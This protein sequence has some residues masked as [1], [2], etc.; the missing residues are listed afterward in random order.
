MQVAVLVL[1]Q[2]MD[3]SLSITLD[4]ISAANQLAGYQGRAAPFSVVTAGLGRRVQAGSGLHIGGLT[5]LRALGV[6]ALVVVP[7]AR[8]ALPAQLDAWLASPPLRRAI[9]WLRQQAQ[10]GAAVAASCAGTFVLAEAGL[11]QGRTATTTWWL[12]PHFRQRYPGVEL[13]MQQMVVGDAQVR[14][15]GAAFSQADLMLELVA[16]HAGPAL[17]QDCARYLMLDRRS[18]QM[19]YAIPGHLAR[20][21]PVIGEAERWIRQRLHRP[22][23]IGEL[24]AA[25]HL[26]PRTLARRFDS[27][28]G[29]SPLR[30]VQRLRVEQARHL[31][32]AAR[33]PLQ[34]V[35]E[36][37]GYADAAT[38]RRLL[39]RESGSARRP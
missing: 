31:I 27:S 25:L 12:A 22:I 3:S 23:H 19:R 39:L 4:V 37:V 11:L 1:P 29:M 21:H 7:G 16:S 18:S 36:R 5:P 38:L 2:V 24:A 35:A 33:L 13:D 15:G 30:F 32:D 14:C 6:P 17:A 10:Q 8:L 26:T 20:Q 9:G 34:T 28:L